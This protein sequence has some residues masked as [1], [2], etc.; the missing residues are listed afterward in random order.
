MCAHT[1]YRYAYLEDSIKPEALVTGQ[2]E[3]LRV[4]FKEWVD[5]WVVYE[6]WVDRWAEGW[7]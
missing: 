1:R 7:I 5:G 2:T 6:V 4:R 3:G